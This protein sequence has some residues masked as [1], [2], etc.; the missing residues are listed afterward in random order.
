MVAWTRVVV[1]M[2]RGKVL[3][4]VLKQSYQDFLMDW[5]GM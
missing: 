3:E 2:K 5:I 4:I 1:D